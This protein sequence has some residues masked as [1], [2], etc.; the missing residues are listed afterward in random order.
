M[1]FLEKLHIIHS[2][3]GLFHTLTAF[4]AMFFG[5]W[6]FLNSKGTPKT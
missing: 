2:W 4:M 5:T 1:E 6:V 3:T